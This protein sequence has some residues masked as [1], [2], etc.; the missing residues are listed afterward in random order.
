M[1][2]T[3]NT[4]KSSSGESGNRYGSDAASERSDGV[5][6]VCDECGGELIESESNGDLHCKACGLVTEVDMIDHGPE[7]RDFDDEAEDKSRVGRPLNNLVHDRGLTTEIHPQNKDGYGNTLSS[8]QRKRAYKLREKNKWITTGDSKEKILKF[9]LN[10]I[11]RMSSSVGLPKSVQEVAAT[12]FR[13]VQ[14]EGLLYGR[15]VEHCAAACVYAASRKCDCPRTLNELN[16]VCRDV[17]NNKKQN[18]DLSIGRDYRYIC[19]E[20]GL[21]IEPNSPLDFFNRIVSDIDV[22]VGTDVSNLAKKLVEKATREN[23]HSGVKPISLM[24]ASLFI[25]FKYYNIDI[26]Q[27]DIAAAANISQATIQQRYQDIIGVVDID[28][29]EI[30]PE[31]RYE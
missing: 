5:Q 3:S 30:V 27:Y 9:G 14:A 7:W 24:A 15:T 17:N 26:S 19:D 25:S 23:L 28:R 20:L 16:A 12:L 2:S 6:N 29:S 18:Y 21:E 4:L 8:T 1:S 22:D 11:R 10:E 13:R 31:W